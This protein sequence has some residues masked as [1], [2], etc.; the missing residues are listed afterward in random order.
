M[1][2]CYHVFSMRLSI[3]FEDFGYAFAKPPELFSLFMSPSLSK[4]SSPRRIGITL[5]TGFLGSGKSTLIHRLLTEQHGHRLVV[6]ENEFSS[7]TSVE[8]AIVTSG[9]SSSSS[10]L[11]EFVELPNG[12]ICCAAQDELAD[13]LD[14]LVARRSNDFDHVVVEASGLADPGPVAASLWV[15]DHYDSDEE[16]PELPSLHL[17][18]VVTVVDAVHF[19]NVLNRVDTP[20]EAAIARKQIALADLVLLNKTD[21]IGGAD[22]LDVSRLTELLRANA[23]S[24]PIIPTTRCDVQLSQLLNIHGFDSKSA[25]TSI[26]TASKEH[27][28]TSHSSLTR[29]KIE[30]NNVSFDSSLLNRALGELLWR[31]ETENDE[32]CVDNKDRL[33]IWRMKALVV[34]DQQPF[35]WIYQ[36]VHTLFDDAVSSIPVHLDV[37]KESSFLFIGQMLDEDLIRRTLRSATISSGDDCS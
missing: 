36:S 28:H 7:T 34:V 9:V 21:L 10:T 31:D 35:K 26:R 14:R 33:Q 30:M 19:E 15:D 17:D 5:I 23:C 25:E 32:G 29:L 1:Q 24:A 27:L 2:L 4:G 22:S 37:V 18:A 11:A 20:T 3:C 6:V 13:A 12:C 16:R 8:K